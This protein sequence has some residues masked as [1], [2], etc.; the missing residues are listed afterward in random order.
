MSAHAFCDGDSSSAFSGAKRVM[1]S[2][3]TACGHTISRRHAD[4]GNS[5]S[6][7]SPVAEARPIG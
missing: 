4:G 6:F 5:F 7:F 2:A 1:S 3:R